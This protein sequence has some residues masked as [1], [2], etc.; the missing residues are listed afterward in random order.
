[1]L[2]DYI[3]AAMRKAKYKLLDK[4]EGFFGEIPGFKGLW[5]NAK[6]LE[7]CRDELRSVL[8]DWLIIKLRHNDDDLPVVNRLNLNPKNGK[9][10][11]VA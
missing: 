9:R 5:A 10:T 6:S 7:G 2:T 1:M 11:K 3:E 8:E 4:N